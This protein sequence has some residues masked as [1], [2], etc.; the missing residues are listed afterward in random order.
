MK[1]VMDPNQSKRP[2]SILLIWIGMLIFAAANSVIAKLGALGATHLIDG[3]NPISF[4]NVLFV[5]NLIAG[6]TLLGIH[7][8]DWKREEVSKISKKDWGHLLLLAILS[9]VLGPTLF[10]IGL[11]LTE[12]INVVLISTIDIPLT[13]I[14]AWLVLREKPTKGAVVASIFSIIG[15]GVVFLLH[16]SAMSEPMKMRMINLGDGALAHFLTTLPFAGGLCIIAAIILNDFSVQYSKKVMSTISVGV[17]SV[18]RMIVGAIIFFSVAIIVFGP[19]H[20]IDVFSPFLW[21]WMLFYGIIIIAFGLFVW[22]RGVKGTTGSDLATSSS[23]APIAGVIFAFLILGEVPE[24][25]QIIG[26]IIIMIGVA[27]ALLDTL[28]TQKAE[29]MTKFEKKPK[30]YC[31]I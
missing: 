7:H 26:G 5:A 31:G 12:V 16:A 14:F 23:F 22:Y 20:F 6:V 27:F 1:R 4:C 10:F 18:F 13:L 19:V 2:F 8:K 9:G 17:F 21:E 29:K 25:G 3:R 30:S 11:M 28:K 15:I 24:S